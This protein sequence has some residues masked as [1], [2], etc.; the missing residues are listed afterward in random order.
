MQ[1][2]RR[3]VVPADR[4]AAAS[5]ADEQ[6]AD[7]TMPARDRL[8]DAPLAAVDEPGTPLV[9]VKRDD[10]VARALSQYGRAVG[11]G[12]PSCAS[13]ERSIVHEH[14]FAS[15]SDGTPTSPSDRGSAAA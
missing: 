1:V 14:M 7:P 8:A 2:E 4:A 10:A 9:A 13:Y 3:P 5:L 15:R 11:V 12:R 6:R